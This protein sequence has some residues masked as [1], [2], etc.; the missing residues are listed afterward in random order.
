MLIQPFALSAEF[1]DSDQGPVTLAALELEVSELRLQLR[2]AHESGVAAGR[3]EA[4][5]LL[6]NERDTALLATS[7]ALTIALATLD[8]RFA[9]LEREA[10]RSAAGLALDLAD[11][12][13]GQ[14]IARDP[15]API[16]AMIG[17]AL[18]QVRR[19]RPLRI[20]VPP[21]L[22]EAVEAMVEA[23]QQADRRRLFLTVVA[24]DGLA[25]G[26]ARIEWEDGALTLDHA[27][28][29]AAMTAE[30]DGALAA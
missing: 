12:L 19:G 1:H 26:D 2:E 29:L 9:E 16:D 21:E 7:E 14:A 22:V 13:A 30:I 11:H 10:V 25:P 27:A 20:M 3:E 15:A 17:K 28:R 24:D 5:A 23:R 4:L 8:A 6:R 18:Q